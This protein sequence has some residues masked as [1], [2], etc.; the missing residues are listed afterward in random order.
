M[1]ENLATSP[2]IPAPSGSV[3]VANIELFQHP[4]GACCYLLHCADGQRFPFWVSPERVA[5]AGAT[6]ES[7]SGEGFPLTE[8]LAPSLR[9]GTLSYLLVDSRTA[10]AFRCRAICREPSREVELEGGLL[11][12]LILSHRNKAPLFIAE[13][14][15]AGLPSDPVV[16]PGWYVTA[17]SPDG[18]LCL[19]R[20]PLTV[21]DLL[22]FVIIAVVLA[23][24]MFW[25]M[26]SPTGRYFFLF[27]GGLVVLFLA[28]LQRLFSR[29]WWKVVPN[30]LELHHSFLGVP[31]QR[32]HLGATLVI[33]PVKHSYVEERN[34]WAE[35]RGRRKSL[36]RAGNMD[37]VIALAQFVAAYTGWPLVHEE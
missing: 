9:E 30:A 18:N 4:G 17:A 25:T 7:Q 22:V 15:R 23:G 8:A 6:A 36:V 3:L 1:E 24:G 14:A 11:E 16:P 37:E 2:P 19:A 31:W 12:G 28:V 33:T 35:E 5:L 13:K 27:A 10:N 34:L 26:R 29:E 21:W 20:Q 32:R